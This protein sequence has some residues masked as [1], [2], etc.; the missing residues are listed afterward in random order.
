MGGVSGCGAVVYSGRDIEDEFCIDIL[1]C[2]NN[3]N[4]NRTFDI[5]K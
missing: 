3:N 5:E 4:N 2:N 1:Q